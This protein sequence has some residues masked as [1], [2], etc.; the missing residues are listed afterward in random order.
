MDQVTS[1]SL[2]VKGATLKFVL[3]NLGGGLIKLMLRISGSA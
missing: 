2:Q 3:S 1:S